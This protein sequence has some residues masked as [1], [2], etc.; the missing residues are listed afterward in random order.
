MAGPLFRIVGSTF[1]ERSLNELFQ[2]DGRVFTVGG[3][4]DTP[5]NTATITA[6]IEE[7]RFDPGIVYRAPLVV[8]GSM[9]QGLGGMR[10]AQHD[11]QLIIIG[12]QHTGSSNAES[13]VYVATLMSDGRIGKVRSQG[14]FPYGDGVFGHAVVASPHGF[15]YVLS[16]TQSDT[17][18][19]PG[20]SA[21]I[22]NDGSLGPWKPINVSMPIN[23]THPA[24]VQHNGFIYWSGGNS[25]GGIIDSVYVCQARPDGSLG[26]WRLAGNLSATRWRHAMV[27]YRDRLVVLGGCTGSATN[28]AVSTVEY[29]EI[30]P[31]GSIGAFKVAPQGM[32]K[33][34]RNCRAVVVNDGIMVLGGT[35]AGGASLA[36]IEW[37]PPFDPY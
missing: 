3:S 7:A 16:G 33:T 26:P 8:V 13:A 1:R 14:P 9:P 10:L 30:N 21:K 5:F 19:N 36:D 20:F 17:T 15:V 34:R 28:T 29:A 22:Q 23:V 12:G 6:N 2:H 35:E 31:D 27:V 4:L 32:I 11:N 24:M 25:T 18:A 37:T